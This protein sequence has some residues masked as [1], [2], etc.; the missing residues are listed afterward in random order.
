MDRR[1]FLKTTGGLLL[2][3]GFGAFGPEPAFAAGNDD[4]FWSQ[5][6]VLR[7]KR[8]QTGESLETAYWADG[9]LLEDGYAKICVLLRDTRENLAVWMD[10]RLLDLMRAVQ[11]Y[12]AYYGFTQPMIV[13][14]GYRTPQTNAHLEGAAKNSLHMQGKA[15]DFFFDRI[16]SN[17]IG[18]LASHYR[19]G[20]VG[21]YPD[22][23]FTHMDTGSIRYWAKTAR[24]WK[25]K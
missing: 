10:P 9:R 8:A 5:P 4:A 19:G 11:A 20:G 16:P 18:M 3:G 22:S 17:Y 13:N 24:P 7:L 25:T 15:V 6:R 12:M 14:S 21:F 2:A 23:G 1:S